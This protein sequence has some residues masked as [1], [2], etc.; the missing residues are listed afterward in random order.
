MTLQILPRTPSL[1]PLL[2]L[3]REQKVRDVDGNRQKH[4]KFLLCL[5]SLGIDRLLKF[6]NAYLL[7]LD[8]AS[9]VK[10]WN[11]HSHADIGRVDILNRGSIEWKQKLNRSRPKSGLE[12]EW[13]KLEKSPNHF[14]YHQRWKA[15]DRPVEGLEKKQT[16]DG[17]KA[18]AAKGHQQTQSA[19]NLWW[20]VQ[21]KP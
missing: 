8:G 2:D 1:K 17:K 7:R 6:N 16:E 11:H 12:L 9:F 13:R 19:P 4:R 3:L 15:L 10:L 18:P 20:K 14:T 5:S 21:N